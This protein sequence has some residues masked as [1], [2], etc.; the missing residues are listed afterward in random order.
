MR[1][2]VV[3]AV[4]AALIGLGATRPLVA[5]EGPAKRLSSI[6]GVAIEE[7]GKG[8]DSGGKLISQDEYDEAVSFLKDAKE[9]AGRLSGARTAATQAILD[10]LIAAV[11][12]KRPPTILRCA[13]DSW[14][15]WAAK[16]HS[17][18]PP[19]GSTSRR[20]ARSTSATARRVMGWS[21]G[22]MDL[23]RVA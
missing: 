22:A 15:R 10:T 5:Q 19:S 21:D 8:I 14:R 1:S 12:A 23:R 7:Y 3:C 9:V 11:E 16:A 13:T 17:T 2:Q 18:F 20:G 6:V 4:F